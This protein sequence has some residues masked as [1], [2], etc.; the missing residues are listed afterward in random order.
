MAKPDPLAYGCRGE[1]RIV[2]RS[3]APGTIVFFLPWPRTVAEDL[4]G[5]GDSQRLT[6]ICE[7]NQRVSVSSMAVGKDI[8]RARG[9]AP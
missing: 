2:A 5:S 6:L 8:I 4:K 1:R 3:T 9:V 7:W